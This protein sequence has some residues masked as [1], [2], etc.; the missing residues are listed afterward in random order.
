MLKQVRNYSS[1]SI[2]ELLRLCS[3]GGNSGAWEEFVRRFHR[4]IATVVLRMCVR[5]GTYDNETVDD[6]IQETYLKLC[7]DDARLLRG[8]TAQHPGAFLGYVKVIAANVA[9]DHFRS[10]LAQ[11]RGLPQI[12]QTTD[13]SNHSIE[14]GRGSTSDI[15]RQ[16]LIDEIQRSLDSCAE[17]PHRER[18]RTIFWL[19]Y[20]V[21]L[22]ASAIATLPD[23]RLTTKGVESILLRLTNQLR[24]KLVAERVPRLRSSELIPEGII[25]S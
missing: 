12:V 13:V 24:S 9:R 17:G 25:R 23:I 2:E 6:L 15:E 18:N 10:T 22:S 14:R 16:T 5:H 8:F 1:I 7:A 11:K 20:R 19:Y 4:L 21:G 3:A